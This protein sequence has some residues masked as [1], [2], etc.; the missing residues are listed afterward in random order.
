MVY[1]KSSKKGYAV[2]MHYRAMFRPNNVQEKTVPFASRPITELCSVIVFGNRTRFGKI[3]DEILSVYIF[4]GNR[5][6]D[7]K[8]LNS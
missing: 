7:A 6:W 2:S 4:K 3:P 8:T 5:C 1:T